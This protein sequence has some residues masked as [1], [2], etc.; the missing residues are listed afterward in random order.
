M[1]EHSLHGREVVGSIPST[2]ITFAV[3]N[4]RAFSTP[5]FAIDKREIGRRGA[6]VYH[7]RTLQ[8]FGFGQ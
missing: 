7:E 4:F 8:Q 5:T 3:L 6:R 2:S 1:V